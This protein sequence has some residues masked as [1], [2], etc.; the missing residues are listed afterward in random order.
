MDWKKLL[1]IIGLILLIYVLWKFNIE[2]IVGV[3][4]TIDPLY[5]I[6]CFLSMPFWLIII[7]I[8]WQ[9]I[10]KQQHI[11]VS[12]PYTIKNSFI[13]YFYGF[14]TP[15]GF[16][17]YLRALYLKQESNAPLPKCISNI[18]TFNTIDLIM[19][20]IFGSIGGLF[21]LGQYPYLILLDFLL[22]FSIIGIFI[23]FLRQK[24]SKQLFERLLKTQIFQAIQ[25]FTDDPLGTFYEDLPRLKNLRIPFLISFISWFVFFTQL[26]FIAQ[27]FDI[28]LP[29]LT[30]FFMCAIAATI[31]AIPVSLYGV[32]TRDAALIALLSMYNV[33]PANCISFTLFWFTIFWVTPSIIGA[34]VTLIE[35]K[36]LPKTNLKV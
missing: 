3:F 9:L 24:K 2:K 1:P 31:A 20:F 28:R 18:V 29:Y 14:S 4:T 10:L 23:F 30:M 19:L 6:L 13:G 26:Y 17:N 21:L 7:N 33:P 32:G 15:G 36:K 34:F 11:H 16:G 12:F 27:L 22:L 25:G 35:H 8:E 5:A